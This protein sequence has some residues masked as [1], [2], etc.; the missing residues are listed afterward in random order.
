MSLV[1]AECLALVRRASIPWVV[2]FLALRGTCPLSAGRTN[3]AMRSAPSP[4]T[5]RCGPRL[6]AARGGPPVPPYLPDSWTPPGFHAALT[7]SRFT[8]SGVSGLPGAPRRQGFPHSS[9]Y[10]SSSTGT[11]R[12]PSSRGKPFRARHTTAA[13]RT[14]ARPSASRA[15]RRFTRS[16]ASGSSVHLASIHSR[17]AARPASDSLTPRISVTFCEPVRR[18]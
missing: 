2:E 6:L 17:M 8:S 12:Q 5:P 18:N 9:A 13:L 1:G 14:F 3:M 4:A 10:D 16:A 7:R 15:N 11:A